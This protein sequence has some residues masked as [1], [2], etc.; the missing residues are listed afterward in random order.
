MLVHPDDLEEHM[1]DG[2]VVRTMLEAVPLVLEAS[3]HPCGACVTL[4]IGVGI[5]SG[6]ED[7]GLIVTRVDAHLDDLCAQLGFTVSDLTWHTSQ[8]TAPETGIAPSSPDREAHIAHHA[9]S[10][11]GVSSEESNERRTLYGRNPAF[12]RGGQEHRFGGL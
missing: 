3:S 11:C 1:R 4:H 7:F 9:C 12:H 10:S 6:G 2:Q 8:I 5:G